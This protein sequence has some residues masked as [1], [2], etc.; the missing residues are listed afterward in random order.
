VIKAMFKRM[1]PEGTRY[2]V[3]PAWSYVALGCLW[4]GIG[5][6][7]TDRVAGLI[8]TGAIALLC[9]PFFVRSGIYVTSRGLRCVP[10]SGT[11]SFYK[12]SSVKAFRVAPAVER[13][14]RG[15]GIYVELM[16]GTEVLLPTTRGWS[17][18]RPTME[19]T[20]RALEAARDRAHA[21]HPPAAMKPI[22]T[23]PKP[24]TPRS[25]L[26]QIFLDARET[27]VMFVGMWAGI[28]ALA[29]ALL[30]YR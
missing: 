11:S 6:A 26:K 21:L 15:F 16:D 22:R 9:T 3:T 28:V 4:L 18:L 2:V 5:A 30:V 1:R 20:C 29:I 12:W 7:Q 23:T 14:A 13:L 8:I 17:R 25:L 24:L 19:R 10:V 27:R